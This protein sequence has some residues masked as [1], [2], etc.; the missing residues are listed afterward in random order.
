MSSTKGLAI[1][2]GFGPGISYKLA[3]QFGTLY[4]IVVLGRS[5]PTV[6]QTKPSAT[7]PPPVSATTLLLK[8]L[9]TDPDLTNLETPPLVSSIQTDL[10]SDV[11]VSETFA[12][13]KDFNQPVAV[14]IF[15][16]SAPFL[17]KP[18]LQSTPAEYS[19]A[20]SISALGSV[21]FA[22]HA[23]PLLLNGVDFNNKSSTPEL[24]YPPTLFFTGATAGY[25]SSAQMS[26]FAA[27]KHAQRAIALS[28]AREYGP[29]GLHV[30]L[31]NIDGL[32]DS[33]KTKAFLADVPDGKLVPADVALSYLDIHKQPRSAW[34]NEFEI[35][36]W[37]ESW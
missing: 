31:V 4:D 11:S 30:A 19:A 20:F 1:I 25:K 32:V 33:E 16:A 10:A 5:T 22:Q 13:I 37:A 24:P 12:Q 6:L 14:A 26:V 36:P 23:I 28:V 15:N 7:L 17:R 27:A 2:A 8:S 29:K 18:F 3:T 34:T 35:R 9:F 21:L